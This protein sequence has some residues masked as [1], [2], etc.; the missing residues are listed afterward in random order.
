VSAALLAE[1]AADGVKLFADAGKLRVRG[2]AEAVERWRPKLVERKAELLAALSAPART[3]SICLFEAG[4]RCAVPLA[5][6]LS[7]HVPG[8]SARTDDGY[9]A[10]CPA[11]VGRPAPVAAGEVQA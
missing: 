8:G 7:A 4:G 10:K 2:P 6:G 9:A 3:C 5:S 1:A 11:F